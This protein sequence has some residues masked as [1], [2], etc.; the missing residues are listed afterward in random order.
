LAGSPAKSPAAAGSGTTKA[1]TESLAGTAAA[2]QATLAAS[3]DNIITGCDRI[4]VVVVGINL[5]ELITGT[6]LIGGVGCCRP[7]TAETASG[8]RTFTLRSFSI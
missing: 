4:G 2:G 1:P 5:S 8:Q 3:V 7:A 6:P